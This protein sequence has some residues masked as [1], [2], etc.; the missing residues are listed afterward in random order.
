M[1]PDG[2]AAEAMLGR[3]LLTALAFLAFG[4]TDLGFNVLVIRRFDAPELLGQIN[5]TLS[6]FVLA[7]VFYAPGLGLCYGRG[8]LRCDLFHPLRA[9]DPGLHPTAGRAGSAGGRNSAKQMTQ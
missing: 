7:S 2:R 5:H 9:T 6:L 3:L 1:G 4:L 8:G